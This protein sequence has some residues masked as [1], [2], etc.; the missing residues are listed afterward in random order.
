MDSD[1]RSKIE[2]LLRMLLAAQT[3]V[4]RIIS[5][6]MSMSISR[7]GATTPTPHSARTPLKRHEANLDFAT[8]TSLTHLTMQKVPSRRTAGR[9]C[10]ADAWCHITN[11]SMMQCGMGPIGTCTVSYWEWAKL[12]GT[13]LRSCAM[14]AAAFALSWL[15]T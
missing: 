15:V 1:K 10:K 3:E 14:T 12:I 6:H 4:H 13:A 8:L 5:L 11:R 2:V 7:M 9:P